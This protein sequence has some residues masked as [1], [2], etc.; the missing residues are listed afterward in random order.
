MAPLHREIEKVIIINLRGTSGSGKSTVVRRLMDRYPDRLPNQEPD[1]RQPISYFCRRPGGRTL[2][3]PGH[4]ETACGGCD[5]IKTPDKVYA[6]IEQAL[7]QNMDVIYEGIIVQDD[8]RRLLELNARHPVTVIE[9]S[10]S[11]VECLAGIQA[12]RDERGDERPLNDKNTVD[13]AVRVHKTCQKLRG[14]GLEIPYLSRDE[15][16]GYCEGL[17]DLGLS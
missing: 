6:L 3:V 12:R 16:F 8:T 9:L 7:G 10:T 2:Y 15:A 11:I 14:M 17:L 4:Y 5:T 1:R 13:R